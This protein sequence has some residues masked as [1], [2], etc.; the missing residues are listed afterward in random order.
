M[1]IKDQEN[2]QAKTPKENTEA[3]DVERHPNQT[4][5]NDAVERKNQGSKEKEQK[6]GS[7]DGEA[8]F[9]NPDDDPA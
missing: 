3:T 2:S 9:E 8:E 5:P 1:E 4:D 7:A 6:S